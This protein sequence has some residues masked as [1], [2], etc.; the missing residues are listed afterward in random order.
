VG[1][2]DARP[3]QGAPLPIHPYALAQ[4][5]HGSQGIEIKILA[6]NEGYAQ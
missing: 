5:A 2:V 1:R 6:V 3:C 4:A